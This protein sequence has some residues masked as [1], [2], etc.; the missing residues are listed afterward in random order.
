MNT[1][2]LAERILRDGKFFSHGAGFPNSFCGMRLGRHKLFATR[3]GNVWLTV[4]GRDRRKHDHRVVT[5]A[6]Y[7]FTHPRRLAVASRMS[8]LEAEHRVWNLDDIDFSGHPRVA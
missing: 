6:D 5:Y 2:R 4:E 1:L 3:T 8:E 7:P